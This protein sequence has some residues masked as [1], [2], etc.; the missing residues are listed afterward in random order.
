MYELF[1]LLKANMELLYENTDW[2][3]KDDAKLNE[4]TH[5]DARFLIVR[6][7]NQKIVGFSHFR[8][9]VEQNLPILYCYEL[10]IDD[11]YQR[12]GIGRH[13]MNI[14]SL[15][16]YE[17]KFVKIVLTVF[18]NNLVGINFYMNSLMFKKDSTCPFAEEGKCYMILRK[19]IDKAEISAITG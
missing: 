3:W 2:G 8:F 16:A 11:A 9:D 14:L 1:S 4:L 6:D 18:K 13:M 10:Q 17:Y 7:T 15:L 5:K 12:K 19:S